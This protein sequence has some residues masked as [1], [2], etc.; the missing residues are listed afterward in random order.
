M[1]VM[2]SPVY[3]HGKDASESHRYGQPGP[4][5]S[6]TLQQSGGHK[7]YQSHQKRVGVGLRQQPH[8][9]CP[10]IQE[11]ASLHGGN[12]QNMA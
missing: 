5:T 7:G 1:Q 8:E 11:R 4:A 10:Y 3:Q 6:E 12:S 2:G 9:V